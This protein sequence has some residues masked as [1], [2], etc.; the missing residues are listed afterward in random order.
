M[1][2]M[3]RLILYAD[4]ACYHIIARGNQKQNIFIEEEDREK[5]MFIIKH[6]KKR[7]RFWLYSFCLM[8]NHIHLIL[9]PNNS[10]GSISQIMQGINLTYC[11]WFNTKYAKNGHL[12]QGR[13][14]SY[15]IQKNEYLIHCM[16]YVELNPVRAGL[17]ENPLN[18]MWSSHKY[19]VLGIENELINVPRL[20]TMLD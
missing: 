12:W 3:P 1:S 14:K 4:N 2:R 16:N 15:L 11:Q 7:Y 10:W 20:E 17:V 18:Y 8:A 5:Y 6:Y 13:F 9:E 19:R